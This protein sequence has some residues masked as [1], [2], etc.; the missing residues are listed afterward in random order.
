[1]G[2]SRG[3]TAGVCDASSRV[4]RG[5]MGREKGRNRK[6]LPGGCNGETFLGGVKRGVF[7]GRNG[8]V[9]MYRD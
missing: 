9:D 3:V 2:G 5:D 4:G 6:G 8:Y 7:E 1:M